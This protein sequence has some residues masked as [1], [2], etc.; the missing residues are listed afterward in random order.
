MNLA[1]PTDPVPRT[2]EGRTAQARVAQARTALF[3]PADR[4]ERFAKAA[5]SGADIVILDLEDAVTP[6][7]KRQAL[8]HVVRALSDR[9]AGRLEAL[10][11]TNG[12]T[13]EW[14][15]A[16]IEALARLTSTAQHG[17]LGIMLP[18][19]EDSA[20]VKAAR[21]LLPDRYA[22]VPLIETAV[23]I[24]NALE[25]ARVPGVDRLAFGAV[26]LALDLDTGPDP[27]ALDHARSMVVLA[28]RAAR[29]AAPLDAP[30]T[31]IR[32]LERIAADA[33]R[34]RSFGFGG[35]LCIHPAQV[36][37]VQN[38]YRPT[39]DELEWAHKVLA[40]A[41]VGAAQVDG[42]MIDRP[43]VDRA[44]RVIGRSGGRLA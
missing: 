21:E 43:V 14:F 25:I 4:P 37:P 11:R 23:G 7:G 41:D 39:R 16:E 40:V 18:K 15:A 2:Q 17:M 8:G 36:D 5:A 30:P 38:A 32:N 35:G 13:T 10:V 12:R 26:D 27:R 29:I 33:A 42:E 34:G 28:S 44:R 31:A 9:S 20:E 3:V 1:V 24:V 6:E 19:A 22:L